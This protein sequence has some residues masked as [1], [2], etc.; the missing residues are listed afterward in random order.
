MFIRT[1][2][3]RDTSDLKLSPRPLYK[4]YQLK[5]HRLSSPCGAAG[6][7]NDPYR[8]I[9]GASCTIR[10][11][12]N[13]LAYLHVTKGGGTEESGLKTLIH[14]NTHA[15]IRTHLPARI[16]SSSS[17]LNSM[18]CKN[19]NGTVFRRNS[20]DCW[21]SDAENPFVRPVVRLSHYFVCILYLWPHCFV[22][23]CTLL[24]DICRVSFGYRE[25]YNS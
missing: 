17:L 15:A 21:L 20:Y 18:T 24:A 6:V 22:A 7:R 10:D 12:H 1:L 3:P 23:P 13:T 16:V 25:V 11:I 14:A 5:L 8:L 9:L 2:T 19:S 4:L